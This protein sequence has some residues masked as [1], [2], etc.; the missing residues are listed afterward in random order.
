MIWYRT[1]DLGCI[2]E[3]GCLHYLG[4]IDDQ[5]K[6]SGGYR[7]ELQEIDLALRKAACTEEAV[8]SHGQWKKVLHV[9]SWASS[10]AGI[11]WMVRR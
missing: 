7:V 8:S 6:V 4:R 10:A 2:D 11:L 9:P 3:R 5:V 1:G